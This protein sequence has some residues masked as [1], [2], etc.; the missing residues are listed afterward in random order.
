MTC[1]LKTPLRELRL[2]TLTLKTVMLCALASAQRQQTL[3]TLDLN[4]RKESRDSI[5]FVVTDQLKT[6]RPGKSIEIR[7][8]SSGC[9][10]I[11]PLLR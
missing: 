11:C 9:P 7:F 3:S 6:A 5:S 10:L 8:S 1:Y 4:F 2:K